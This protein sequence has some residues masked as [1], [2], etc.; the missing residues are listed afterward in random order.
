MMVTGKH[1]PPKPT[2]ADTTLSLVRAG[3]SSIPCIGGP[4]VELFNLLITPPLAKRQQMWREEIG[5]ALEKLEKEKKINLEELQKDEAFI[6]VVLQASQIAMRTSQAEKRI[7]LRNAIV[8]SALQCS[9]ESAI[10]Q[11]FLVLIDNFNVWHIRLLKLM[12]NPKLWFEV[13]RKQWPDLYMG[14]RSTILELAYPELKEKRNFYDILWKDLFSA[15]L[16]GNESLHVTMTGHGLGEKSTTD[17][18]DVFISFIED[19]NA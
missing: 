8:N 3:V 6:D 18:G 9:I 17:I 14:G 16:V 4:A 12:K 19:G 1:N 5:A 15:G 7:A 10:R 13:N 2:V 11:T